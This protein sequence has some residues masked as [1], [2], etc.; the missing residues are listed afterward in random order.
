MKKWFGCPFQGPRIFRDHF[1]FFVCGS[2]TRDKLWVPIS[3]PQNKEYN[4]VGIFRWRNRMGAHFRAPK[5]LET[6]FVV[7][8]QEMWV[9]ISGPQNKEI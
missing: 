9:P 4:S 3:G 7:Q 5:Y 1:F 6:I 2:D 8:I